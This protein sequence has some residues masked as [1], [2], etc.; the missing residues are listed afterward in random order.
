MRKMEAKRVSGVW[1]EPQRDE[2]NPSFPAPGTCPQSHPGL[3]APVWWRPLL[4]RPLGGSKDPPDE[5]GGPPP[6]PH[7]QFYWL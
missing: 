7:P 1:Q 4:L 6:V 5:G 3:P 2:R